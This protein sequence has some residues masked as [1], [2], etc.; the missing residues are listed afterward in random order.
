MAHGRWHARSLAVSMKQRHQRH[1]VKGQAPLQ[2]AQNSPDFNL[3]ESLLSQLKQWQS[4]E[5]AT[6]M[7]G[8]KRIALKSGGRSPYHK[9]K[10]PLSQ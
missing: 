9:H 7:A 5:S 1:S 2:L 4:R 10:T 8:L 6:W 3:I